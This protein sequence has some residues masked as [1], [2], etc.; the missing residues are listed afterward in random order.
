MRKH[1]CKNAIKSVQ[2]DKWQKKDI[3]SSVTELADLGYNQSDVVICK[4]IKSETKST[5][6]TVSI[7]YSEG[8]L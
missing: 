1:Y 7:D 8:S 2:C 3:R 5:N 6:Y 4:I